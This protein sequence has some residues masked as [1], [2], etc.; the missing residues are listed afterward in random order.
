MSHSV[1]LTTPIL[2]AEKIAERLGLS[3][4]RRK[5]LFDLVDG[6]NPTAVRSVAS[7]GMAKAAATKK[8]A[9]KR[10]QTGR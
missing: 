9:R 2:S 7:K 8:A 6:G 4:G 1:E 10:A 3:Q 5:L